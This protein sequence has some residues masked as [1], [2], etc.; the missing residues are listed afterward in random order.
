MGSSKGKQF[1]KSVMLAEQ[2]SPCSKLTAE[3]LESMLYQHFPQLSKDY[4][5]W[6]NKPFIKHRF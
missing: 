2:N 1:L 3:T 4:K 6:L 5:T